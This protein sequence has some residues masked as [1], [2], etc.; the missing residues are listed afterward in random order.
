[1]PRARLFVTQLLFFSFSAIALIATG[2]TI[3]A[4]FKVARQGD[5]VL[6]RALYDMNHQFLHLIYIPTAAFIV[7]TSLV[8]LW[9]RVLPVFLNWAGFAVGALSLVAA[10]GLS[11]DTSN[12]VTF[13]TLLVF[14]LFA[15]WVLLVSA[16]MFREAPAGA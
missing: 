2:V 1:L 10:G 12:F 11:A 9:T 15:A 16:V 8:G 14:L 5:P 13:L 7:F 3:T 4:V 6:I